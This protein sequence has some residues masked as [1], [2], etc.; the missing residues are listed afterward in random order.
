MDTLVSSSIS[1]STHQDSSLSGLAL[2]SSRRTSHYNNNGG[3]GYI[4]GEAWDHFRP[5][6]PFFLISC[7][8][9]VLV[10]LLQ[11]IVYGGPFT[12]PQF[13]S[14]FDQRWPPPDPPNT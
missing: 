3:L 6:L 2:P 14:K 5:F 1:S 12:D 4:F 11:T 7:L 9:V 10:Y 13:F 8:V